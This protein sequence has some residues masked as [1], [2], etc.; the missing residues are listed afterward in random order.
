MWHEIFAG[1]YLCG[2]VIFLVLPEPIFAIKGDCFFSL[3]INFC[4]LQEVPDKSLI[5]SLIIFRFYRERVKEIHI[6]VVIEQTGFLS[7]VILCSEFKLENIY[8][9]VNFSGKI[10]LG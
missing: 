3:G 4:D 7:T 10:G 2:L 5:K 6:Q 1:V 8:S 9:R